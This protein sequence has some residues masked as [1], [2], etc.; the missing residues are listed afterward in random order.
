MPLDLGHRA[1]QGRADFLVAPSNA[2]ALAWIDR[3]PDWPVPALVL[4]GPSGSGKSHLGA[5]WRER[6][7]A[8]AI[9]GAGLTAAAVPLLLDRESAVLIDAAAAA[10]EEPLL[11]LYNGMAE[12]R[13]HLLLLA[14]APPVLWRIGLPDLRSRLLATPVATIGPPDDAL[15]RALLLK[16]FAERQV[17]VALGVIDYLVLRIERS[18]DAARRVV[19]RLDRAGF[20]EKRPITVPL[21]RQVLGEDGA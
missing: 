18:G 4:E 2:A 7:G 1:A 10:P 8:D 21:A 13:G 3:W 14:D 5:I 9:D 19:A 11:H 12:R 6:S 16:L 17:T 20:E 15:I